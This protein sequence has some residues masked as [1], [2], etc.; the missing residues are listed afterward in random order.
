M[1]PA[2]VW[3]AIASSVLMGL[4]GVGVFVFA[5]LHGYFDEFESAKYHVFWSELPDVHGSDNEEHAG[6]APH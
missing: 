1:S 5:V 4:G 3:I 6:V 2:Y